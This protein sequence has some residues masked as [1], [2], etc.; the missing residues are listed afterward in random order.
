VGRGRLHT[1]RELEPS[2]ALGSGPCLLGRRGCG[3]REPAGGEGRYR[4]IPS[5]V[6]GC[7]GRVGVVRVIWELFFGSVGAEG[8]APRLEVEREKVSRD[9][10]TETLPDKK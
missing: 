2:G 1:G 4:A 8:S 7:G 3:G 6:C 9:K 5:F 10:L